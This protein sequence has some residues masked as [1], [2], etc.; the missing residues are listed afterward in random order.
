MQTIVGD[1]SQHWEATRFRPV[2]P[3]VSV[4]PEW[5][6]QNSGSDDNLA[7]LLIRLPC[8]TSPDIGLDARLCLLWTA[9]QSISKA[10]PARLDQGAMLARLTPYLHFY[11]TLETNGLLE[12]VG[13]K[14]LLDGTE[15]QQVLK[16]KPDKI[17]QTVLRRVEGWQ[18]DQHIATGEREEKKEACKQWL[19]DEWTKG[20]IVP[21]HERGGEAKPKKEAKGI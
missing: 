7:A 4:A 21:E 19:L 20:N 12:R 8:V 3:W 9:V 6:E 1:I 14:A 17:L 16:I 10:S 13:E 11:Q 18:F 15:V 2:P 5:R